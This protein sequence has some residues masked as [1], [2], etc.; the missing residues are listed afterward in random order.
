M[1]L[2]DVCEVEWSP[3]PIPLHDVAQ[4]TQFIVNKKQRSQRVL[5]SG[6]HRWRGS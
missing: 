1:V 6:S 5:L 3:E 2:G 4:H